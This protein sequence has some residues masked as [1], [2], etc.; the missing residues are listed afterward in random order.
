MSLTTVQKSIKEAL[1]A[2][3][4]LKHVKSHVD[5]IEIRLA[6]AYQKIKNLDQLV[7]KELRDIEDLEKI[8]LKSLF[9]RTL[10]DMEKQ[11][12]K[13][14][15]EYLEI[16]LKYNE[17]KKSIELMEFE[18]DLLSKKLGNIDE[19]KHK[20]DALKKEREAEILLSENNAVK[21][22][23]R[24][25]IH[26]IDVSIALNKELDEAISEGKKAV[27]LLLVVINYL[28]KAG[29]WGRWD[30][31]G[32]NRRAGYLKRQSIENARRNLSQAQHQLNL[33]TRELKDLG[34][35]NIKFKVDT[36]HFNKFTD[37][38]FDNLISDWIIQQR[39]KSTLNNIE[40]THDHVRRI[41]LS[42]QQE[43]DSNMNNLNVLNNGK[44]AFLTE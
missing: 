28:K 16:S 43:K 33:F 44:D 23:L 14:R 24:I 7:E 34:E 42:L 30:M 36:I 19:L 35:N 18:R 15:Q 26:E 22:D 37:F 1:E 4:A 17:Y 29:E 12:E 41:L 21:N 2:H 27:K 10:G 25:L 3:L 11:L 39:I 20:L 8:G 13:E 38:F 40:S 5:E 31:Y 6:E 32:D 9:H